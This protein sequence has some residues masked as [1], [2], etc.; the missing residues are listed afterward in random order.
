M[1]ILLCRNS[2]RSASVADS[3]I[4]ESVQPD[5]QQLLNS[6]VANAINLQ[7]NLNDILFKINQVSAEVR[8][9]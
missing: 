7:E 5:I 4:V 1:L 3:Q 8:S 2:S 9:H 6:M